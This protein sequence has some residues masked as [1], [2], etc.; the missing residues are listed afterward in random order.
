VNIRP[1]L[2]ALASLLAAASLAC[3]GVALLSGPASSNTLQQ[4]NA[5]PT[6]LPPEVLSQADAEDLVLV[7]LYER[8]SPGVVNI[9]V[10]QKDPSGQ[11]QDTALGSG[12]VYDAAGHIITNAHVEAQADELRVR[13]SDSVV[14]PAKVIGDDPY[15]DLAVLKVAPPAGYSLTPLELGDS[16]TLKVGARVVAIG[17]P[18]GLSNTM[19]EG[20]VSAIGR[21]LPGNTVTDTGSSFSNPL[22][23]QIDAAI[24]PGN[25]G[26]PLLDLHGRVIGVN[27]AIRTE[28]G[29]NSGVGFAVPSNTVKRAVPQIIATGKVAYPYLGIATSSAFDLG[30]LA[31]AFKL[32]VSQ[33]V[34][35]STV[36]PGFAAEKA[37]LRGSSKTDT[38]RGQ[39]VALGGDIIVAV[40]GTPVHNFDEL[41]GYLVANTSVGQKITVTII[42]DGQKMDVPVTLDARPAN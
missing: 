24:N 36:Q 6:S 39:E 5:G 40:D 4:A 13:F 37:G 8:V 16:S 12:F 11:L 23:I 20:I 19:T 29:V 41:L 33:G 1:T 32:P 7:N 2:I 34:L 27:V 38:L 35:I 26:G 9:E 18:F 22:I 21:T 3:T 14:L 10:S 30:E 25:S 15:A 28:S 17:N 31:L 42:R